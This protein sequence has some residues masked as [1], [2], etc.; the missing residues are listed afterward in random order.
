MLTSD[1][2]S[3][4]AIVRS[5]PTKSGSPAK[6]RIITFSRSYGSPMGSDMDGSCDLRTCGWGVIFPDLCRFGFE[7]RLCMGITGET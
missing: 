4:L 1:M 5:M 3:K 6:V 7:A 2:A